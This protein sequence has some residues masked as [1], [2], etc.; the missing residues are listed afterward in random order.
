MC[1]RYEAIEKGHMDKTVEAIVY[2]SSCV[3]EI[4]EILE[5]V[6]QRPRLAKQSRWR[7]FKKER[8]TL[9]S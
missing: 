2:N 9:D 5:L 3:V 8:K 7:F 1:D 4:L 6:G